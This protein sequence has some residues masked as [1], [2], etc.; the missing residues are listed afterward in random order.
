[1][2]EKR[3]FVALDDNEQGV[4]LRCLIEMKNSLIREGRYTDAVDDL[5]LKV[6]KAPEKKF[7]VIEVKNDKE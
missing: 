6:A 5:I 3:Y 1:M 7:K 4:M 2:K